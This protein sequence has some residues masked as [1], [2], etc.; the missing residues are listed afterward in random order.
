LYP[1][2]ASSSAITV[3]F[4]AFAMCALSFR[5]ICIRPWWYFITGHCPVVKLCDFA[6]PRPIRIDSEPSL[7]ASSTAP[8]SPVTYRP[9]MPSYPATLVTSMIELRTVAGASWSA[10]DSAWPPTQPPMS[11]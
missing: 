6:Q 7:A 4:T 10:S 9:G 11:T 3:A 5:I 8:G 1:F 2:D